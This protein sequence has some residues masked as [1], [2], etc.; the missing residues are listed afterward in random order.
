[1]GTDHQLTR[2]D[3]PAEN[4][5]SEA[6][7]QPTLFPGEG[8]QLITVLIFCGTFPVWELYWS[9]LLCGFAQQ[10]TSGGAPSGLEWMHSM[11]Q[12]QFC[13]SRNKADMS[14]LSL[15][16][17]WS[18]SSGVGNL[19]HCTRD[20]AACYICLGNWLYSAINIRQEISGLSLLAKIKK[21]LIWQH[22]Y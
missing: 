10:P 7:Q 12:K 4:L 5:P 6:D 13:C 20:W 18:A 14:L 3:S 16:G 17:N 8:A 19:S 11:G 15:E 9:A 21:Y 22:V 2:W 1:M